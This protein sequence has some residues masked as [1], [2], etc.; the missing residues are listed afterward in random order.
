MDWTVCM[1]V[2]VCVHVFCA[3]QGSNCWFSRSLI[4]H[5]VIFALPIGH[6]FLL[7][8][9]ICLSEGINNHKQSHESCTFPSSY[10]SRKPLAVSHPYQHTSIQKLKHYQAWFRSNNKPSVHNCMWKLAHTLWRLAARL[11]VLS[12]I[13]DSNYRQSTCVSITSQ[14]NA[15]IRPG[16]I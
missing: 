2:C 4:L 3:L 15:L 13:T 14:H 1:C 9:W 16:L 11:S 5:S 8:G 12:P 10:P 7:S 6:L